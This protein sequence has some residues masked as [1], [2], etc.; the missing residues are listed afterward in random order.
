MLVQV[1]VL[2]GVFDTGLSVVLDTLQTASEL[3]QLNGKPSVN[4]EVALV[5][6]GSKARTQQG[7]TVSLT[8]A[9]TAPRPDV[10][11]VPALGAKMPDA[12]GAALGRRDVKR[13]GGLLNDWAKAGCTISA[14]CTGTFVVAQSGVLD[15]R[16]ATTTWWLSPLFRQL[17]PSV[18][19]DDSRMLVKSSRFITAGAAL[20]HLDLALFLVRSKSPALAALTA[21]YLVVEQHSSQAAFAIPDHLAHSD[22]MVERFERWAR[23]HL[24]ERFSLQ[25]AAHAAGTSERTLARRLKTTLGKSPLG[26]VQELRVERAV[27]LLQ[28]TG[29]SVDSIAAQVGYEDGITLRNL[30]RRRTGRG[31]R[32]LRQHR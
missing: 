10:V 21:R 23:R 30:L 25:A 27:H 29:E 18:T 9:E 6:L 7:L 28:T 17:F 15:G 3:A 11:I 13:A 24:G 1:L 5:G 20:A 8:R 12:L 31:V 16:A 19:L 14:A 22:A 2:D 4:F 32:E 26:Y